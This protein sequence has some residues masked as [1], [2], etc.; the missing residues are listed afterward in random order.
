MMVND[1]SFN[2]LVSYAHIGKKN[3]E[4]LEYIEEQ[5]RRGKMDIMID[6]GAF[7]KWQA[8]LKGSRQFDWVNVSNYCKW[9]DVHKDNFHKYVM[10]D[11]LQDGP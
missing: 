4:Y 11:K 6:S 9:L 7:S 8:D 3:S 5:S 10:L 1:T 2:I